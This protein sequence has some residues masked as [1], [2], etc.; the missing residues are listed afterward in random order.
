MSGPGEIFKSFIEI[1]LVVS[2]ADNAVATLIKMW[3]PFAIG[4][5]DIDPHM[6]RTFSGATVRHEVLI[7]LAAESAAREVEPPHPVLSLECMEVTT[8]I[9]RRQENCRL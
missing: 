1:D 4:D 3:G 8:W 9:K 6:W 7:K 2:V 5:A